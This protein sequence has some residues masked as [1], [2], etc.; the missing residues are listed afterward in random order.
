M[1]I[2]QKIMTQNPC[3]Q[4]GQKIEVR[5][6]MLHSVGTAQPNAEVFIRQWDKPN[7]TASAVH[8]IIDGNTGAVYRTLPWDHRG[9]HSGGSSNNTHIGVEMCEPSAIKYNSNGT[10]FTV[11]DMEA[12]RAVATRTYNAAV[13]LFAYLCNVYSLDPLADG[14][15][16]SHSEGFKRGVASGHADPEHLWKG[17]GLPYTMDAFRA[18]VY[19]K[20]HPGAMPTPAQTA[21]QT[22]AAKLPPDVGADFWAAESVRWAIS[23]GTMEGYPDGT[24]RPD[25]PVTRAEIAT[26]LHRFGG[27]KT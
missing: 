10:A 13:E 16:I 2:I 22:Q 3:F 8:G 17:L 11:Q 9:W 25:E 24:F 4:Q 1:T 19:A 21:A 7:Y 5:G 14:V 18:D 23:T 12:A 6:L 20:L 26:I 15:I 27:G